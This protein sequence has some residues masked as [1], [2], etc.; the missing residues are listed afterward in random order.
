M[1][2]IGQFSKVCMVTVKTLRHYDSMGLLKPCRVNKE[3]GYRYYSESQISDM[4]YIGKL[5]RC[6]FSLSDIKDILSSDTDFLLSKLKKQQETLC[7][8]IS[9]YQEAVLEID[10]YIK[11]LERTGDI[12]ANENNYRV[13]VIKSD[14]IKVISER[15]HMSV[16]DFGKYYGVLYKRCWEEN[17]VLNGICMAVYHDTEFDPENSDIELAL[18]VKEGEKFDRII[19][20]TQ[21]A[22]T[23]H[24]G[25]YS[26][27]PEAYGAVTKWIFKNGYKI[28]GAPYEI[29]VK[30]QFDKIPVDE[31]ETRIYFPIE[32]Q[33]A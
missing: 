26:K 5:K 8:E 13:E 2:S 20:G 4:L 12:M 6:G 9:Q 19:S 7:R 32:R 1:L 28:S 22:M 16:D 24:Y 33:D 17:I 15:Q 27:L 3:N 14:D 23:T 18:G 25:G 31:W 11:T 21:C 30:T 29:Y 10:E